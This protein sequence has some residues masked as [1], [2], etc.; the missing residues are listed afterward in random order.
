MNFIQKVKL[1]WRDFTETADEKAAREAEAL[2][3]RYMKRTGRSTMRAL[4]DGIRSRTLFSP[5][6]TKETL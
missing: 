1:L 5:D 6:G 4:P 2:R 3:Q